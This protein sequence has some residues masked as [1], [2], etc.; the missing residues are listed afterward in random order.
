MTTVQIQKT[1]FEKILH[2]AEVLIDEVEQA[3]SL[4]EIAKQRLHDLKTKMV[5]GKTE[6]E[7]DLYLKKRGVKID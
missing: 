4:D 3:C 1:D 2:T 6:R 7:L 5:A